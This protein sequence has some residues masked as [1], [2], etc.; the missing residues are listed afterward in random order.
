[1]P[2]LKKKKLK[3]KK[4]KYTNDYNDAK[5]VRN[6]ARKLDQGVLEQYQ[7]ILSLVSNLQNSLAKQSKD[8]MKSATANETTSYGNSG[9]AT[10]QGSTTAQYTGNKGLTLIKDLVDNLIQETNNDIKAG[11]KADKKLKT[12]FITVTSKQQNEIDQQQQIESDEE[13]GQTKANIEAMTQEMKT[14]AEFGTNDGLNSPG[15]AATNFNF[16]E[17]SAGKDASGKACQ[18]SHSLI[19]LKA[20]CKNQIDGLPERIIKRQHE[21]DGLNTAINILKGMTA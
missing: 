21:M 7:Q 5:N 2:K 17:C 12:Q 15:G 10:Q 20:H 13:G 19:S 16:N 9:Q 8:F 4:T 1:M 14:Q 6:E 11:N 3:K 18:Q